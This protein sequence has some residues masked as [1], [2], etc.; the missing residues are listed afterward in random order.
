MIDFTSELGQ[1][2]L[3]L[4]KGQSVI[5]LTTVGRDETPQPRP[6]WFYWDGESVLIYSQPD[7][8][9]IRHLARSPRASLHFNTDDEG[10][11]V[12]VLTGEARVD[13][14]A[15]RADKN[16]DYLRKYQEGIAGLGM[17]PEGFAQDY[18]V[19]IR[20]VPKGLRGF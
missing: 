11:E 13:G 4:L 14:K 19:P 17:T 6:V 15:P 3:T 8:H 12:V 1:R 16:R 18:S 10:S 7:A 5:W 2:A 20:F 9:K